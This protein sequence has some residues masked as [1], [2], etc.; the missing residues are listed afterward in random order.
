[1]K[2]NS[3]EELV[4]NTYLDGKV[5]K[6]LKISF[7]SSIPIEGKFIFAENQWFFLH[8]NVLVLFR[9]NPNVIRSKKLYFILTLLQSLGSIPFAQRSV[10]KL[11]FRSTFHQHTLLC[12]NLS[13]FGS[14]IEVQK[15]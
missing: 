5:D 14:G 8:R 9:K 6:S 2:Q 15:Y 7:V 10:C 13:R 1:M 3:L 12:H 11:G 4:F